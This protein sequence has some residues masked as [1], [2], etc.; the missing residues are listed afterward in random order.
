MV[1]SDERQP[2][3]DFQ[4]VSISVNT[5]INTNLVSS[6]H[7]IREKGSL[8]VVVR[9]SKASLLQ[10]KL[11]SARILALS[12]QIRACSHNCPVSTML[13]QR[14]GVPNVNRRPKTHLSCKPNYSSDLHKTNLVYSCIRWSTCL[15]EVLH[16]FRKCFHRNK[17]KKIEVQRI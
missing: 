15:P 12:F 4:I 14:A 9:R 16:I 3:V 7:I 6:R 5:L 8:P 13:R 1:L 17:D 11:P 2:E 10:L